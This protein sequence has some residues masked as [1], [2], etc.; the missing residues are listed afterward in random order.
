MLKNEIKVSIIVPVYNSGNYL[1]KCLL[2]ISK[3]TYKLLEII[4]VEN[5]STD[6]SNDICLSWIAK[7]NRFKLYHISPGGA[8]IARNYAFKKCTGGT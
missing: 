3:Q 6:N 5:G 1:D 2:S 7:D 8:S 4:L